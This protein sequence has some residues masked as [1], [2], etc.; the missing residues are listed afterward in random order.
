MTASIFF[1]ILAA[2]GC[3]LTNTVT[4]LDTASLIAVPPPTTTT[5]Y[6]VPDALTSNEDAEC[7][8]GTTIGEGDISF[9]Y[10]WYLN[11]FV[12]SHDGPI[13]D[14]GL[15]VR[16]DVLQCEVTP[17]NEGG[18][19]QTMPSP[20][21]TVINTPPIMPNPEL[22]P[23]VITEDT[24][25]KCTV[26][27]SAVIDPDGDDTN[28]TTTWKVND[29]DLGLFTE[30]LDGESF[31]RGD[32]V[33]CL[34]S[35]WDGY[36][37]ARPTASNHVI[38]SDSAPSAPELSIS[39]ANP[40]PGDALVCSIETSSTDADG[41]LPITY[42]TQWYGSSTLTTN[43]V[44]KGTTETCDIWTCEVTPTA[45]N[46]A[47]DIGSASVVI[48]SACE[49]CPLPD[50]SDGDG[51]EDSLDNCEYTY[52]VD[53]LDIDG[54][55]RGDACDLCWLDG[56]TPLG[57]S[58]SVSGPGVWM[59]NVKIDG[60][61]N[62]ATVP[63]GEE[64]EL[65][66]YFQLDGQDCDAC[67]N[68]GAQYMVGW[69]SPQ[70][71]LSQELGDTICWYHGPSGCEGSYLG[72]VSTPMVA[73]TTPGMYY[74]YADSDDSSGCDEAVYTPTNNSDYLVAAICVE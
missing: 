15:F 7:L 70:S 39:P 67:D 20:E 13:L 28:W 42:D 73:P 54:D 5:P 44:P 48:G 60:E 17:K 53:Q 27:K 26:E 19:G 14:A 37:W 58:T 3:T 1:L 64:F 35:G 16:G 4:H 23:E 61:G 74:L 65:Y 11:D 55:D 72:E 66:F 24:V 32:E 25:A 29:I 63:A 30:E 45:N 69:Q 10:K 21:V 31:N 51:I 2:S 47:G 62:T 12:L 40:E 36:D 18:D 46:V 22:G 43:T 56:P 9:Q 50:D 71:C 52:N 49:G 59:V 57:V 68:C 8:L 6:V 41:D 34:I 33:W 38:I